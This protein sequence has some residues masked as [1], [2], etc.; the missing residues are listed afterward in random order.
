MAIE[1]CK[2]KGTLVLEQPKQLDLRP[3]ESGHRIVAVASG[4]THI[5]ILTGTEKTID[6]NVY[7]LKNLVNN[8]ILLI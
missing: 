1:P 3:L 5:L 4:W 2:D 8:Y 7:N 6:V